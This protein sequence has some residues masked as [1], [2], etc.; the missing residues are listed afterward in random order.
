[1]GYTY[2]LSK[3]DMFSQAST[4]AKHHISFF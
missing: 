2:T 3:H 1:L 4:V